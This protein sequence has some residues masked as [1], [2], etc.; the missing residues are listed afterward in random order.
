MLLSCCKGLNK[1][2]IKRCQLNVH[3]INDTNHENTIN[4]GDHFGKIFVYIK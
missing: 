3:C 1:D 4:N 2:N